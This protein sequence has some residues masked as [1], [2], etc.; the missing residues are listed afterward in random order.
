MSSSN[1]KSPQ[2]QTATSSSDT[3]KKKKS[4]A[5]GFIDSFLKSLNGSKKKLNK[6][7]KSK[8]LNLLVL[9]LNPNHFIYTHKDSRNLTILAEA[10]QYLT[11]EITTSDMS[12]FAN[13]RTGLAAFYFIGKMIEYERE[14]V[15]ERQLFSNDQSNSY[16][17]ENVYCVLLS[18][19]LGYF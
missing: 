4:S 6:D 5:A 18:V 14:A 2:G 16:C 19:N 12:Q 10:V 15:G 8:S 1:N 9:S 7:S 17:C 11:N 3:G 13:D